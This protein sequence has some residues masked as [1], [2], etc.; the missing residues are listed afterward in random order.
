MAAP[1]LFRAMRL[2]DLP[3]GLHQAKSVPAEVYHQ[4]A[5]WLAS[6]SGLQV[7]GRSASKYAYWV[8]HGETQ[9]TDA[10]SLGRAIHC[11]ML[12]PERFAREYIAEPDFG[13]CRA[14]ADKGVST[15]QGRENKKRRDEWRAEHPEVDVLKLTAAEERTI[16]GM[17]GAVLAE[18]SVR[19]LLEDA[20]PEVTLRWADG[21]T[22]VECKARLDVWQPRLDAILDLKSCLDASVEA[23]G[24]SVGNYGY[25]HQDDFYR[26]GI[27]ATLGVRP[28]FAFLA[29][30][31]EA[32]HDLMLH[33]IDADAYQ[34]ARATNA[35]RLQRFAKCLRTNTWPGLYTGGPTT[36]SLKP[37]VTA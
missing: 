11:A 6:N 36:L 32:P 5:L 14:N 30:E 12:E 28:T 25:H 13:S 2:V 10:L 33:E 8:E 9:T 4:R 23:F 27:V 29:V 19:M 15:E 37:W 3:H 22:G 18:P 7:F 20:M 31:K 26:R 1:D 34:L 35:D 16:R 17:V 21:D 24:R